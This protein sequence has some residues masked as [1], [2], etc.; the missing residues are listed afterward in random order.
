M[1]SALVPEN[2]AERI[3]ALHSYGLLDTAA[4]PA[5]DSFAMLASQICD[6]PMA[7]VSL[8]D[9]SRQWFKANVGLPGVC[10]TSRDVAFCAHAILANDILEVP[11]TRLDARFA[12]NPLVTGEPHVRFYAG[13]PLIDRDGRAS[14]TL[15]TL[16]RRDIYPLRNAPRCGISPRRSSSLSKLARTRPSRASKKWH[17]STERSNT[18]PTRSSYSAS[19]SATSHRHR[20]RQSFVYGSVRISGGATHRTAVAHACRAQDGRE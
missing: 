20:L 5:F 18:G 12:D 17:S 19:T 15:C 8:V 11:D 9:S 6:T 4:D 1:G 14:G 2:E 13:M 7:F 3:A 10:E 16:D